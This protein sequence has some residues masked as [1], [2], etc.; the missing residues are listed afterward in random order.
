MPN[1]PKMIDSVC[2]FCSIVF[3]TTTQNIKRGHG[4]FCSA[5]CRYANSKEEF[6][7]SFCNT[8]FVS[9]KS[10]KTK[11]KTGTYFCSNVC[12]YKAASALKNAYMTGPKQK[13]NGSYTYRTRALQLL[14]N[15]CCCCEYSEYLELLDVDHI[16]GDRKDNDI[17]NLQILCVMCHAL[18]TRL[19]DEF[20]RIYGV[21]LNRKCKG[22]DSNL[23]NNKSFY[24]R[25]CSSKM[26][27]RSPR[28][29]KI[30][31]PSIEEVSKLVLTQSILSVAK[32]LGVTDNAVR[33]F[34]KKN[35]IDYLNKRHH[36][37]KD[38]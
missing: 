22:C 11:S 30:S 17:N 6:E 4:S 25:E 12:K 5:E 32:K 27:K 28:T 10:R 19:P 26:A 1:K 29:T 15:K 9:K 18:K 8:K 38:S 3:S 21:K 13:G 33:R 20:Q 34:C 36:S 14:D 35:N 7:C 31:W 37:F 23:T 16:N 2:K 24:C